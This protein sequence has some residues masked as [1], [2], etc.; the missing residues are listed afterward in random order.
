MTANQIVNLLAKRHAKDVFVRE[1]KDA[2]WGGYLRMDAWAMDRSWAH[3]CM[4]GYEVKISRADFIGDNKWLGYLA[5]CNRFSFVAPRGIIQPGELSSGVG[6][7]EVV[8]TGNSLRTI[9]KSAYRE[10]D[11]PSELLKYIVMCRVKVCDRRVGCM[12]D[13]D[14]AEFWR[15]WLDR[16]ED[17]RD[18]GHRVSARLR[19]VIAEQIHDVKCE[20]ARLQAEN[21]SYAEIAELLKELN[22]TPGWWRTRD[23][24][25]DLADEFRNSVSEETRE[26]ILQAKAAIAELAKR[27]GADDA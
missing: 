12:D 7:L 27:I 21:K 10:I 18:V 1:C 13:E 25:R 19:K 26:V 5:L 22:L 2:S 9:R 16:K 20:N 14:P 4:H 23:R 15:Q 6:L 3:P 8:S 24:L 17:L 11:P